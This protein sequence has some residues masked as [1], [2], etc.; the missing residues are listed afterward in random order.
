MRIS[1]AATYGILAT[2]QLSESSSSPPIP[3]SQFA[4]LGNMPE[5]FLLQV[6]RT[7]VNQGLLKSTRGV[8]GGYRLS[9]PLSQISLLEPLVDLTL[10]ANAYSLVQ[11][12]GGT[13]ERDGPGAF[14]GP[15]VS[16]EQSIIVLAI[17]LIAFVGISA[18]ALR[19]RD[20]SG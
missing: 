11:A 10:R 18:V 15:F 20:V 8:D 7:L 17:Y 13:T 19:R 6:L 4:K 14:R 9:R 5:R 3:C 16:T 2:V 1:R 12:F